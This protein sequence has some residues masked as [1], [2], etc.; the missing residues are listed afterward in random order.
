MEDWQQRVIEEK[1]ELEVKA[2][3]LHYF[4][5][6][7]KQFKKIEWE[8]QQRLVRQSEIMWSYLQILKDRIDAFKK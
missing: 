8:E 2:T 4:I 6:N 7:N 1:N 3:A 5:A